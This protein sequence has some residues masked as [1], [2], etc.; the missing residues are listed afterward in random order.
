MPL[1]DPALRAIAIT[2]TG[3]ASS[4]LGAQQVVAQG[5]DAGPRIFQLPAG[6]TAYLTV[7]SRDC[8]VDHH[9]TCSEDAPGVQ[10]RVSL[11]ESGMTYLGSIDAETQWLESFHPLSSH[12]ERLEDQPA[13]R[14]S[15]SGLLATG[16]D[17][18]DFRTL[19]DEIGTTR[20]VGRDS[21]TGRTVTIDG[22]TLD[23]TAY[24][25][26]ALDEA[27]DV[28]WSSR[29][30]EYISRDWQMF[31]SGTSRISTPSD[32]YDRDGTPV[33]F[34]FPGEPGFQ[35]INPKHGC[36]ATLSS[37]P[38]LPEQDDRDDRS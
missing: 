34:I 35:S 25:I 31:L 6:C 2:L 10:R 36:G 29:G 38:L 18:Y 26:E 33:E 12:A 19:S 16:E 24:E 23:E 1:L 9:F 5:A 28:L 37:L 14:A 22:I 21:L 11:D 15:F 32:S 13:D 30:N 27:G 4:L 7:Q 17:S 20:Y 8:T 3:A